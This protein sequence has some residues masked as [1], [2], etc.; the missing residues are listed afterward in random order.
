MALVCIYYYFRDINI[1][2]QKVFSKIYVWYYM[3]INKSCCKIAVRFIF[4]FNIFS[5]ILLHCHESIQV[6]P[7][8]YLM[9][10]LSGVN[11]K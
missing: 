1:I 2:Y 4:I 6:V 7:Q 8:K 5:D 10:F 11:A 3:T 9:Y